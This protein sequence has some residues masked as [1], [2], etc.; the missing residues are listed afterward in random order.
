MFYSSL[1]RF[2]KSIIPKKILYSIEPSLRYIWSIFYSGHKHHCN[3]CNTHLSHFIDFSNGE[4]M[5]PRCGSLRR[6]R[7]LFI[8]INNNLDASSEVLHF[9]PERSLSSRLRKQLRDRYITSDFAGEF[10]ADKHFDLRRTGEP[11]SKY[12]LIICYH[13]LEHIEEDAKAIRE[14]YRILKP[15]GVCLVQTPFREGEILEDFSIKTPEGRTEAFGQWDHVRVYSADGL[16]ARLR[17][18]GFR[19]DIQAFPADGNDLGLIDGEKV[20]V[21]TK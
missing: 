5:C 9:S 19:V 1:K 12:G 7:R 2:A 14:L 6:S 16:A 21:A 8:L 11:D 20:L 13:V 10:R 18:A 15:G 17:E 4:L 3:I